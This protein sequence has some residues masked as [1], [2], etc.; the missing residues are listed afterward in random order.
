VGPL[1]GI[2]D[3]GGAHPSFTL[4]ALSADKSCAGLGCSSTGIVS[5]SDISKASIDAPESGA[6]GMLFSG[7][8]DLVL[9]LARKRSI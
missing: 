7:I 6:F 8:S 5:I 4:Q 1:L 2:N 3:N 9:V